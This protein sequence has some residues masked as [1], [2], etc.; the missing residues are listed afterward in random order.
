[1]KEGKVGNVNL[2]YY[3]NQGIA[4]KAFIR[5]IF[6]NTYN[7]D[8]SYFNKYSDIVDFIKGGINKLIK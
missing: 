1:L 8:N 5:G 2:K 7:I 4:I 3:S 6:A